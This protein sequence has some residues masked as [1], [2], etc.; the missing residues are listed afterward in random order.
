MLKQIHWHPVIGQVSHYSTIV[1]KLEPHPELT[2][3][4]LS[5]TKAAPCP[6]GSLPTVD[7]ILSLLA[8]T[9]KCNSTLYYCSAYNIS[10]L[11]TKF[12]NK[13]LN[14]ITFMLKYK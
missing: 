8:K 6:V 13:L 4:S 2:N 5:D 3:T 14:R 10:S 12:N 9:H 1:T 11:T 7:S